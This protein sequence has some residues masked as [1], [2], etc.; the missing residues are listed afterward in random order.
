[1]ALIRPTLPD[2]IPELVRLTSATGV[3]R[4]TEIK[5]LEEVL[6]QAVAQPGGEGYHSYTLEAEGRLLGFSIHGPNTM[7]EGTWDLYWIV[8]R[9]EQHRTGWG[10]RL[11]GFVEEDIRKRGGRLIVAE[12][13]S[14]PSYE[15]TRRF[16]LKHGYAQAA[17]VPDYYADGDSLI[18]FCKRLR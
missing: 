16:Y 9:A 8:V 17:V 11:L 1:M 12:T 14:L 6:D 10:S 15:P 13:S 4:A 5:T 2:D 7:T 18:F 3:F